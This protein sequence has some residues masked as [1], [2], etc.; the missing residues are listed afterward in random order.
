[1]LRSQTLVTRLCLGLCLLLLSWAAVVSVAIHGL[2]A[3]QD[4]FHDLATARFPKMVHANLLID[5]ANEIARAMGEGLLATDADA[6]GRTRALAGAA[7]EGALENLHWLRQHQSAPAEVELLDGAE[8]ARSAYVTAQDHFFRV[9]IDGGFEPA[10][11]Y[12]IGEVLALQDA[13]VREVERLTL[14][15]ADMATSENGE[16]AS[17][18][19]GALWRLSVISM[20]AAVLALVFA[21]RLGRSIT[22]PLTLAV[23][24]ANRVATGRLDL[25]AVPASRD[26]VGQVL[27]ALHAMAD[28]LAEDR[29]ALAESER[30]FR[31]LAEYSSDVICLHGADCRYTYLSPACQTLLGRSPHELVGQTPDAL[32]HPDD[33]PRVRSEHARL[34]NLGTDPDYQITFRVR[35]PDGSHRWIEAVGRRVSEAGSGRNHEIVSVMRNVTERHEAEQCLFESRELLAR[36]QAQAQLGSWRFDLENRQLV[37]SEEAC[38]IFGCQPG[39]QVDEAW[40]IGQVHPDDQCTVAA[41][42]E[43][44]NAGTSSE[45]E[46]RIIAGNEERWVRGRCEPEPAGRGRP[47]LL[48][49]TAQDITAMKHKE[50]ELLDSRQLL[51]ELAAHH[52]Q[53][54]EKRRSDV[55]REIHDELGQCLTALRME[56][57]L[58]RAR[59]GDADPE[60]TEHV[61]IMKRTI[62][63]TMTVVRDVVV[64][65]R[66]G[67]L[68]EG[69]VPAAEWLLTDFCRR[70]DIAGQLDAPENDIELDSELA[71][72]AFRILQES[73]TNVGKHAQAS[74]VSISIGCAHG[75]LQLRIRDDGVGFDPDVTG[76]MRTFGLLGMRERALMFSGSITIDSAPG[77]GT[78]LQATI[79]IP[80][81]R[82]T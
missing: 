81:G 13:Y 27:Q 48:L 22:G 59:F 54:V 31:M 18:T 11:A 56:A 29:A 78:T 72:A 40:F 68:D 14:Y 53:D 65:L 33:M 57:A 28:K 5:R 17:H 7:R 74:R 47:A 39:Q 52:E 4:R 55:A 62:D 75:L 76:R 24:I 44:A 80:E 38:R 67:T 23:Q 63:Q 19:R 37:L 69:L 71:T 2:T 50:A 32:V 42:W 6:L 46:Y 45:V 77:L 61:A 36:S 73:L 8:R 60:I 9:T 41:C 15:H 34:R 1:M 10:R 30:M 25:P 51:R 16:I 20:L 43:A 35:H 3:A 79:P 64:A 12:Y 49:G 70:T 58:L 26:E 21:I 66:P 82:D